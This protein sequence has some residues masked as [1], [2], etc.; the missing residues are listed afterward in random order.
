[1]L[2]RRP[3]EVVVTAGADDALARILRAVLA[4]GRNMV[5]PVPT[6][7]MI[8]RYARLTGGDIVPVPWGPG[9]FPV[10]A[11]LARPRIDR[12]YRRGEPQQ[13]HGTGGHGR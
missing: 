13:P 11:V 4:P 6:F 10:E 3:A 5:L 2:G 12:P 9:P 1:M 7:E 8:D